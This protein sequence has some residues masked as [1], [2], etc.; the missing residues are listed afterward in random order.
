MDRVQTN[1][2]ANLKR[3]RRREGLSQEGLAELCNL[4]PAYI[5]EIEIGRKFPS[6]SVFDKF[7]KALRVKPYQLLVDE[8]DFE[9]FDKNELL[10]QICERLEERIPAKIKEEVMALKNGE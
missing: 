1:F 7:S 3:F 5:G 6:H 4:T 2:I 10:S 8:N 9:A